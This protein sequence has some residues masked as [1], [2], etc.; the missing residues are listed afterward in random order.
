MHVVFNTLV[1]ILAIWTLPW[2]IYAVWTAVKNGQKKWFLAMIL[3]NTI[4]ILELYYI[5]K[6]AKKTGAEVKEDF[7]N[8]WANFK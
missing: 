1:V 7:K 2:K 4:S 5:F 6:V 3:L 8:A